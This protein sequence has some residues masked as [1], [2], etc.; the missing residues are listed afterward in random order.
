MVRGL[1]E[2]MVAKLMNEAAQE[3]TQKGFCDEETAKS[4]ESETEKTMTLD[5]LKSRLDSAAAKKAEL[6]AAVKELESE[7]AALDKGMAEATKLREEEK[8][9]NDKAAADY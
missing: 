2:S 8:A 3:A 5:K 4:K 6:T 9:T 1:I 7:I